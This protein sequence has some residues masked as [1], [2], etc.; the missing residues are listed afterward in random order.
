MVARVGKVML[1]RP[2]WLTHSTLVG[3]PSCSAW[4]TGP[5]VWVAQLPIWPVPKS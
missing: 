1:L 3:A 2:T 4:W 5:A